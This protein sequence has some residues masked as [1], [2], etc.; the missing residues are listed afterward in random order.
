[1]ARPTF[2]K[3]MDLGE[4]ERRSD[5]GPKTSKNGPTKSND[6][7]NPLPWEASR[8]NLSSQNQKPYQN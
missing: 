4:S 8:E 1:M 5:E 3:D 7:Q 6:H 2:T